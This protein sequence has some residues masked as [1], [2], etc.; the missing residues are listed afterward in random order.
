MKFSGKV[1]SWPVNKRLNFDIDP[2]HE[3]GYRSG[4]TCFGGGMHCPGASSLILGLFHIFG[5]GEDTT[6]SLAQLIAASVS[7]RMI[8]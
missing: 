1:G 2:D 5:T 6:S 8:E 3:S 4:K 7:A